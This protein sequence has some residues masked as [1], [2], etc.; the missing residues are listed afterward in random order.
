MRSPNFGIGFINFQRYVPRQYFVTPVFDNQKLYDT[1]SEVQCYYK[2]IM[3][4]PLRVAWIICV[5]EGLFIE[6][7]FQ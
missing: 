7:K 3:Q 2:S 4:P 6:H 1:L 5:C